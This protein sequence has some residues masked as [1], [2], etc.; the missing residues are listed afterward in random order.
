MAL[1]KTTTDH[2]EIKKWTEVRGAVPAEVSSTH[3]GKKP[4]VLR[5]EF[6]KAKNHNDGAL[7]EISWD[8]FFQKS[9]RPISSWLSGPDGCRGAEQLQQARASGTRR[10]HQEP[11]KEQSEALTR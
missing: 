11:G 10:A 3:S 5:F 6:P 9:M 2:D 7:G 1:S 8:D 4:G